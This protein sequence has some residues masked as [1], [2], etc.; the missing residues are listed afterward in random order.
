MVAQPRE[1]AKCHWIV[2]LI[3]VN[4]TSCEFY[5]NKKNHLGTEKQVFIE[6]L[7]CARHCIFLAEFLSQFCEMS[8]HFAG[9]ALAQ[10]CYVTSQGHTD[11]KQWN[12]LM[13]SQG[14][15][16]SGAFLQAEAEPT[17]GEAVLPPALQP[18]PQP[19]TTEGLCS[20]GPW[21]VGQSGCDPEA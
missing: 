16:C 17:Q 20:A 14:E 1:C 18:A 11:G 5:L 3:M 21:V 13:G 15:S 9:Q 4:F 8:L 7:L 19:G 10:R 2:H 6:L 12:A